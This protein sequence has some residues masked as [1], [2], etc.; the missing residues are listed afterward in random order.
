MS[1]IDALPDIN[2]PLA[3]TKKSFWKGDHRKGLGADPKSWM[4]RDDGKVIPV[5]IDVAV[6]DQFSM[7][8]Q[9]KKELPVGKAQYYGWEPWDRAK[10]AVP[11]KEIVEAL[12]DSSSR[13]VF[14]DMRM[15]KEKPEYARIEAEKQREKVLKANLQETKPK[16]A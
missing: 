6:D 10:D 12:A 14:N 16:K 3:P 7:V 8:F 13:D 5:R 4:L 9:G 2:A 1:A 11:S 15:M